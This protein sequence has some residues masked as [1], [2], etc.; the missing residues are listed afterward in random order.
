MGTLHHRVRCCFFK[1]G[2]LEVESVTK[3][4]LLL[5]DLGF[6]IKQQMYGVREGSGFP[7]SS[8]GSF[9]PINL[10]Y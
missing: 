6:Y 7:F 4:G 2:V 9:L 3:A 1:A 5:Y 8:H 10:A